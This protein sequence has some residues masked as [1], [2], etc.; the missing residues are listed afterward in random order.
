MLKRSQRKAR[1]G[2]QALLA[3]LHDKGKLTSMS[4][5]SELYPVIRS[6]PRFNNM[7]GQPGSTPLDLFKFFVAELKDRLI[8]EKKIIKVRKGHLICISLQWS[9]PIASGQANTL[10]DQTE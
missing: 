5:W 3:D 7:L 1:E 4:L 2:F 10:F 9:T 6:D 8:D